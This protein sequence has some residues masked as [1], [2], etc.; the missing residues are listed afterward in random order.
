MEKWRLLRRSL[1]NNSNNAGGS[2]NECTAS[3][4][5]PF[6]DL[7]PRLAVT[8][9]GWYRVSPSNCLIKQP[10]YSSCDI[11]EMFTGKY[12][13]F[14]RTGLV[15]KFAHCCNYHINSHYHCIRSLAS[16]RL[17][18]F[19]VLDSRHEMASIDAGAWPPQFR[20]STHSCR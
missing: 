14:L 19:Q 13:G 5:H 20:Y 7:M 2:N 3:S 18:G 10:Q 11:T 4:F 12:T 6:P 8:D 9:D 1:R 17:S 16:R 15:S